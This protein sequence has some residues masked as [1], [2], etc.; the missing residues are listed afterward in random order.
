MNTYRQNRSIFWRF[1]DFISYSGI[2]ETTSDDEVEQKIMFNRYFAILFFVFLLLGVCN[3]LFLGF[4]KGSI[5]LFIIS[6]FCGVCFFLLK[7]M[8]NNTILLVSIFVLLAVTISYFSSFC[9]LESGV[10]LYFFPLLLAIP[11]FF[12]YTEN[13]WL[14]VFLILFILTNVYISTFSHFQLISPSPIYRPYGHKLLIIN[15][16]CVLLLFAINSFFLEEKRAYL[17]FL[18]GKDFYRKKQ[19]QDLNTEVVRLKKLINQDIQSS[20]NFNDLIDSIQLNDTIFIERFEKFFPYFFQKI[21]R[22]AIDALTISDLKFCALL[23]LNFTTK[24]IA[25]YT[26][27]TI[28]SAESKKYRLRKKLDIPK[29]VN[30]THYFSEF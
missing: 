19:V 3:L 13:K 10:F 8:S 4:T 25:I 15:I 16:T 2:H 11:I 1:Y 9:G 6:L 29:D 22:Q 30:I 26:N 12:N 24:Q 20:T 23:K 5:S 14:I 27:S 28:K 7:S 18:Q 21:K 17:E